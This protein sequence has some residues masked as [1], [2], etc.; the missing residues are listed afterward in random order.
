MFFYVLPYF[1]LNLFANNGTYASKFFVVYNLGV[2]KNYITLDFNVD[3]LYLNMDIFTNLHT[4]IFAIFLYVK[5]TPFSFH[6]YEVRIK[7]DKIRL[8]SLLTMYF[9]I[10]QFMHIIYKNR[11]YG[12]LSMCK[13]N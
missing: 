8:S 13:F 11:H 4:A 7:S 10:S 2:H 1:S 5:K 3:I 12:C 9:I 6:R